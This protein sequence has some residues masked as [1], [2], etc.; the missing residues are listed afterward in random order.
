M[1]NELPFDQLKKIWTLNLIV[2]A[3]SLKKAVA[4]SKVSPSAI[5]QTLSS[6]EKSIGKPLIIRNRGSVE[7][8]KTCKELLDSFRPAFQLLQNLGDPNAQ[9]VLRLA[10]LD[11][12]AY[13]SLAIRLFPDF[14]RHI[15]EDSPK[16]KINVVTGRT[17][18]LLTMLRKGELCVAI[19]V[20]N[21]NLDKFYKK[22]LYEDRLGFY[23][24]KDSALAEAGWSAVEAG[25]VGLLAAGTDGHPVYM[26]RFLRQ[27]GSGFKPIFSSDSY[28]TLLQVALRGSLISILPEKLAEPYADQLVELTPPSGPLKEQGQHSVM[29]VSQPN[30]DE[31][32]TQYIYDG[33]RRC[34][35]DSK[36]L[37]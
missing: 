36:F 32:E 19:V 21:D 11:I 3:G 17:A 13:E 2:E 26:S 20:N 22:T 16:A 4:Q 29:L 5:S 15:R 24:A 9:I 1:R 10:Y 33:L 6:L 25:E 35:D 34:I 37:N 27:L 12:G 30:C 28:D 23:V 31:I 18:Q 7:P 8:T 14:I